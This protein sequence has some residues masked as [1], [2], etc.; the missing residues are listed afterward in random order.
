M[1][2]APPLERTTVENPGLAARRLWERLQVLERENARL[3]LAL[4]AREDEESTVQARC[5]TCNHG[6]SI[7]NPPATCP[8]C[9][10][11]RWEFR[12]WRPFSSLIDPTV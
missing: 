10:G 8:V 6:V 3:R 4:E 5:D 1:S 2:T 7:R 11:E 9:G 12:L